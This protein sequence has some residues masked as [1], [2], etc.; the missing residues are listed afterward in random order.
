MPDA[1]TSRS[2]LNP[3]P[4][5][6]VT[7]DQE[8]ALRSAAVRLAGEFTGTFNAETIERF[9]TSS[10]D[11]FAGRATIVNY[12]P[13]LAERFARERLHA[14]SRVEGLANDGR[15]AVLFLCTHNAGRSQMAHGV[16]LPPCR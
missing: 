13:L 1:S 2:S 10:Y 11:E 16:L 6:E 12:L 7:L 15:A 8:V 4:E 14:L 5:H 9:L 3:R